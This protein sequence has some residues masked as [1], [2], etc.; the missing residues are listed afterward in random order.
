MWR[1][2]SQKRKW[3]EKMTRVFKELGEVVTQWLKESLVHATSIWKTG[4]LGTVGLRGWMLSGSTEGLRRREE[5]GQGKGWEE[6]REKDIQ[7]IE[8]KQAKHTRRNNPLRCPVSG[9]SEGHSH[10]NGKFSKAGIQLPC[11]LPRSQWLA[12]RKALGD[13]CWVKE[14][15]HQRVGKWNSSQEHWPL[16]VEVQGSIPCTYVVDPSCP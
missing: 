7:A 11:W 16:F 5:T 6:G 9:E 13:I 10:Q 4:L 3:R 2:G 14:M 12:Q 1:I 8:V 15:L